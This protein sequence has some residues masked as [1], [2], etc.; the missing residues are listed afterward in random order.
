VRPDAAV[1]CQALE[2]SVLAQEV[3]GLAHVPVVSLNAPRRST[4]ALA[5]G[6]RRAREPEERVGL[7]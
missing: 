1:E 7:E 5:G 6:R 3:R 2:R 4:Q